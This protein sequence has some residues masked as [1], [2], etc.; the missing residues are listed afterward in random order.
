MDAP[1]ASLPGYFFP[2]KFMATIISYLSG[3]SGGI[4]SPCLSIGAGLG[5][6]LSPLFAGL[7]ARACALLGMVAFF[8]GVVHAPLTAVII[9][10]EMTDQHLLILPFLA[11]AY[12]AQGASML[13]MP[14]PLY[15]KLAEQQ[16]RESSD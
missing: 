10:M 15:R 12:I 6:A 11:A 1:A 3:I 8:A 2:A 7:D 5:A 13:V 4:F 9:I 14:T 16:E